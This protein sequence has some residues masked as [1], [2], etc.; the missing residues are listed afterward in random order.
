M[1]FFHVCSFITPIDADV[2]ACDLPK[3]LHVLRPVFA[4]C[5]L[6]YQLGDAEIVPLHASARRS[7]PLW[8]GEA[9]T[10]EH[11]TV[12]TPGPEEKVLS[13]FERAVAGRDDT[14]VWMNTIGPLFHR[15]SDTTTP[16]W[17]GH[18]QMDNGLHELVQV[19]LTS[20]DGQ[21]HELEVL[22]PLIGYPLTASRL[23][24]D[25]VVRGDP[26]AAKANREAIIPL[27]APLRAAIGLPPG[28]WNVDGEFDFDRP[29]DYEDIKRMLAGS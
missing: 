1:S 28:S 9:K 4:P 8:T 20:I 2:H 26:A 27:I 23:E 5:K 16:R 17:Y 19:R 6:S 15:A 24:G 18:W 25:R 10:T 14:T 29:D 12:Y 3:L 13:D 11:L 21:L 22:F 7:D